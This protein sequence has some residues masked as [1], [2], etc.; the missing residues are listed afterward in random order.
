MKK[1]EDKLV[2]GAAKSVSRIDSR[3]IPSPVVAA[4]FKMDTAK[5]PAYS[6]VE[7]PGV[8]YALYKLSKVEAGDKLDEDRQQAM[9]TQLGNLMA[10]EE[11]RLY[12]DALRSRYKVEI[13][14]AVLEAKDK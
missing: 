7:L 6:G 8:G 2:W 1:G 5:L 9:L 4:L 14:A 12:L 3:L 11:M 13:N 10:Q